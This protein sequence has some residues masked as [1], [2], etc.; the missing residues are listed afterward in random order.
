MGL[1]TSNQIG[2]SCQKKFVNLICCMVMAAS[3]IISC[4]D[5]SLRSSKHAERS[6]SKD[7]LELPEQFTEDWSTMEVCVDCK[8]FINDIISNS[9]RNLS[10]KRARLHRRTHSVYMSN[11]SSSNYKP[12]E[13]TIKEV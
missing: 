11:T 3:K 9:R 1:G 5:T 6:S 13:R 10:T 7:E 8:K 2:F 4:D 12:S